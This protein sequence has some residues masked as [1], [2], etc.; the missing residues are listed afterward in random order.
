MEATTKEEE[1]VCELIEDLKL[2][3]KHAENMKEVLNIKT[4]P[5]LHIEQIGKI[6]GLK[7]AILQVM[8]IAKEN[9]IKTKYDD[10]RAD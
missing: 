1:F 10:Q 8:Q 3:I 6:D 7:L 4:Q 2:C 9:Q 5:R